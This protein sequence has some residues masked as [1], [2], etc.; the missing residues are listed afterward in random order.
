MPRAGPGAAERL[1]VDSHRLQIGGSLG[2]DG[3]VNG[4][5]PSLGSLEV[6]EGSL[7]RQEVPCGR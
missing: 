7:R 4:C 5:H 6:S 1:R 2:P 3:Y